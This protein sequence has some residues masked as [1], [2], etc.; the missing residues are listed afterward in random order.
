[1]KKLFDSFSAVSKED[2]VNVLVKE[3][4]GESP[5][6][7]QKINPIEEIAFPSYFHSEDK[8]IAHS[9]PGMAP[10]TRGIQS[11]TNEWLIGTPLRIEDENNTNK[12][13]LK[14]LME[15][16]TA[17]V[18]HATSERT[19]EFK[20]L[21]ADVGL[22]F[23]HTSFYP[24]TTQQAIDFAR[25]AGNNPSSIVYDSQMDLLNDIN[26]FN[27]LPIKPFG[28]NGYAVNQAG[29]STWQELSIALAEGHDLIIAQ[30]D[31]GITIDE[32][33]ANIHFIFGIGNQF[34]FELTKLKAFRAAWSQIIK[35]YSP[36]HE[37]SLAATITA[38]TGFI[39]TSLKDPYTNLLRQTTQALSAVL[40][41]VQQ[42]VIQPYD[43]HATVQDG[44]FTQRM[45]ANI[46]LLLV[47]ESY[48]TAVI[49]PAGGSYALD[50]LTNTIAERA[51]S[52]FQWIERNG[53]LNDAEVRSTLIA[54]IKEKATLRLEAFHSKKEQFI[55]LNIFPNPEEIN[56]SWLTSP[57]CWNGMSACILEQSL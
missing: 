42:V 28:I 2:W 23:I 13:I 10:Y 54:E 17:L 5:N 36:E 1:M 56:N 31:A 34:Y 37:C 24:K 16:T 41:G 26:V 53:G 4:K 20:H 19:I 47:E 27:A 15:G 33:A 7:L 11:K 12:R 3:L 9:D 32:A 38:Q 40:G 35:T 25:F 46:S 49:D 50:N 44:E 18:L 39:S 52:Q 57:T 14:I 43:W 45:A 6:L 29:A 8:T 22:E 48:L 21:L 51:W 55:G 30:L